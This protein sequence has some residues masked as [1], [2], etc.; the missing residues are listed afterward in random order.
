[1]S[2][3]KSDEVT[4]VRDTIP[5]C[6]L[7]V[8]NKDGKTLFEHASGKRGADTEEPTALDSTTWIASCTK[9]ISRIVVMQLCEQSKLS[10]DNPDNPN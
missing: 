10:L 1:M 4:A 2:A 3:T 6:V 9:I 5:G 8:V 7:A